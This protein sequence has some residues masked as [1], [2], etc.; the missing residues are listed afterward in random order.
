MN[1]I[2]A[3]VID[4]ND[5]NFENKKQQELYR[6]QKNYYEQKIK[7]YLGKKDQERVEF[8]HG[9]YHY[10]AIPVTQKKITYDVNMLKTKLD[11]EVFNEVVNKT[12][13]INDYAGMVKYLKSLGASPSDFKKFIEVEKTVDD[14]KLDQLSELGE[15]TLEDLKGCYSVKENSGYIRIT[16]KDL[17][18]DEQD[19]S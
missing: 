12:Y 17:T 9:N 1:R 2:N 13:M 5:L 4:L 10:S 11:K 14:K 3:L 6:N 18:E 16:V 7:E 19:N 8:D 15:I